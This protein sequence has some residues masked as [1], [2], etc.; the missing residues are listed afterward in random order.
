[1]G[2]S[3]LLWSINTN[4]LQGSQRRFPW[5]QSQQKKKTE[6]VDS[7][8]GVTA[9]VISGFRHDVN[10]ICALVGCYVARSGISILTFRDKQWVLSSRTFFLN[11]FTLKIVPIDCPEILVLNHYLPCVIPHKLEEAINNENIVRYIK[12]KRLSWLGHVERMTNER[13]AKTIY[14]W[15][16]C[17]TR[18]KGRPRIRWEGRCE[19][20]F[21]ED[22]SEWLETNDAGEEE[23]ER[24]NRE[25]QNP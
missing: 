12:Y 15:K 3:L 21:E 4:I 18:P 11:F 9:C 22:G 14:K 19:E 16:P 17:G 20:W 8:T 5:W 6:I 23:M 24:N 2:F 10:E 25:S 13:V 1:M 7:V